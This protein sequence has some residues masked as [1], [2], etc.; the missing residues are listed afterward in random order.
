M[1]VDGPKLWTVFAS[2]LGTCMLYFACLYGLSEGIFKA[3]DAGLED[4]KH[5]M[6]RLI[7]RLVILLFAWISFL[8]LCVMRARVLVHR[9]W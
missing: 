2:F 6:T 4:G 7:A 9:Y 1:P 5:A 8:I 3:V